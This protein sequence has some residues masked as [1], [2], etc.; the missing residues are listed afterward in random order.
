MVQP[1]IKAGTAQV[2]REWR[3]KMINRQ[4]LTDEFISLVK[5]DSLTRQERENG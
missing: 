3:S 2:I 5:I 4:R 1:N